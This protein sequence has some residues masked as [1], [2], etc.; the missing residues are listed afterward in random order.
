VP[1]HWLSCKVLGSLALLRSR[2][3]VRWCSPP[4]TPRRSAGVTGGGAAPGRSG[5]TRLPAAEVHQGHGRAPQRGFWIVVA[6][7]S[8]VRD[9]AFKALRFRRR[10]REHH[11][12]AASPSASRS[13]HDRALIIHLQS[14]LEPL[15]GGERLSSFKARALQ[16][17][18]RPRPATSCPPRRVERRPAQAVASSWGSGMRSPRMA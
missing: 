9:R 3:R 14:R 16:P 13:P 6:E 15:H 4:A 12:G 7:L 5:A 17:N 8:D 11:V 1:A 10:R 2:L 18:V